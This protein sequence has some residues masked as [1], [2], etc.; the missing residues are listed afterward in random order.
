MSEDKHIVWVSFR[1]KDQQYELEHDLS[2]SPLLVGRKLLQRAFNVTGITLR[3]VS[4]RHLEIQY[5]EVSEQI[6]ATDTSLLGTLAR[7]VGDDPHEFGP[8]FLYHHERFLVKRHMRLRLQ[9]EDDT[10]EP[11]D[12]IIE[13]E[14][15]NYEETRPIMSKPASW[16]RMLN[17]LRTVRAAH[18]LGTPGTGKTTLARKLV[19][20]NNTLWQRQRDRQLGGS[21]L[22][23]WVDCHM[24]PESDEPLWRTFSRQILLAVRDATDARDMPELSEHISSALRY[25]DANVKQRTSETNAILRGALRSVIND[26]N[27][28]PVILF[29]H[30]DSVFENV[31][32]FILYQLFQLHQWHDISEQLQ[33]V[34]I[35][36]R[37]LVMLRDDIRDDGVFEF[38]NLFARHA[39][40]MG[41]VPKEE[42]NSLWR[43]VAPEFNYLDETTLNSLYDLSGGHPGLT[44]E[45]FEELAVNG[46][47]TRDPSSWNELLRSVNWHVRPSRSCTAIWNSMS[48]REQEAMQGLLVG[49]M[50]PP[51]VLEQFRSLGILRVDGT[52]FSPLFAHAIGHHGLEIPKVDPTL[53]INPDEQR[54]FVAGQDVT[55]QLNGRKLEVLLYLHNHANKLCTYQELI[56]NTLPTDSHVDELTLES[57]RGSLQRTVSRLCRIVDPKR[58][59]ICN[60]QGRG[61]RLRYQGTYLR[62]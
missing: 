35:T 42:F 18:L 47:L 8:E 21:T 1:Y 6:W 32:K 19:A 38:V 9:N 2:E 62:Q 25:F 54:V 11:D 13:L 12:I 4:R 46:W 29:D 49:E 55:Q 20:P 61:Y 14:N 24:L 58:S 40:R 50:P 26:G 23:A 31:D 52:L 53:F 45:L 41:C 15:Q 56:E 34:I 43:E 30:F 60:E 10:R 48:I 37:P 44:R 33:F 3:N 36:R 51:P 16:D 7:V 39:I 28:L 57:E 17:H 5:D 27:V 59:Y 22:V